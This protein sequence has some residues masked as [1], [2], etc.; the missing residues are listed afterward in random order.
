[1]RRPKRKEME[2]PTAPIKER[3]VPKKVT[4]KKVTVNKT[5]PK[6]VKWNSKT[7]LLTFPQWEGTDTLEELKETLFKFWEDKGKKV[8]EA[9]ICIEDHGPVEDEDIKSHPTDED[10]G[11]HIHMCFKLDKAHTVRKVDFFDNLGGKHGNIQTCRNYKACQIYCAKEGN[12][13]THNVDIDAVVKSTKSKKGVKHETV[14]NFI[15]KKPRDVKQVT[16]KYPGYA[17]QHL[18]KVSDFI[19]LVKTFEDDTI[20]YP[21]IDEDK[22][23]GLPNPTLQIIEWLK[24]NL[25]PAIRPMKQKQLWIYGPSNTGK[26]TLRED[27]SKWFNSYHVAIEG[28]QWW[29]GFSEESQIAFFEEFNGYKTMTQLKHFLDGSTMSIPIKGER[30][31][32][33]K[34][35]NIPCIILSNHSPEEVY[36]KSISEDFEKLAPVLERVDV[37]E[38][39]EFI[40]I[41]WRVEEVPVIDVTGPSSSMDDE[42]EE[43]DDRPQVQE[44]ESEG[45]R[46]PPTPP[47]PLK[48]GR[49]LYGNQLAEMLHA[50]ELLVAGSQSSEEHVSNPP[51]PYDHGAQ[52]DP[53]VEDDEES[54]ESEWTRQQRIIG[55]LRKQNKKK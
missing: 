6:Q 38:V 5:S 42:K 8:E 29:S 41:P 36:R 13:T 15:L 53:Y 46:V 3:Q 48:R 18:N 21:G 43:I 35:R 34:K 47:R 9:I 20:P 4:K 24:N 32:L 40:K 22:I 52:P 7:F 33:L 39:K 19:K 23:A 55:K 1:M 12:Y 30:I 44:E 26:T 31:P 49:V 10:P 25:P 37:I 28:G 50:D 27:L 11:R 51:D 45:D 17:I 54:E 14:A 16:I 2:A